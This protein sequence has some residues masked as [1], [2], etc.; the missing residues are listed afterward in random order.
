MAGS[1]LAAAYGSEA[2]RQEGVE[3]DW[4]VGERTLLLD[5]FL[6]WSCAWLP[7]HLSA[8]AALGISS[9]PHQQGSSGQSK[10]KQALHLGLL[11]SRKRTLWTRSALGDCRGDKGLNG[12]LDPTPSVSST[13]VSA[14]Q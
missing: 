10:E 14:R 4:G 12:L 2:V 6:G 8:A 9:S 1:A 13:G 11:W 3:A 7:I 5:A